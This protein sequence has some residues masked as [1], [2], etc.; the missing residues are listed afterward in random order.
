[1]SLGRGQADVYAG[2]DLGVGQAE[3]DQGQDFAFAAGYLLQ[4]GRRVLL[5]LGAAGELGDEPPG[6]AGG[7]Q[8]VAGGDDPDR[9]RRSPA[10]CL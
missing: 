3:P 4:R 6:D 5:G 7:E 9:G 2:C 1:M 8:R 10:G